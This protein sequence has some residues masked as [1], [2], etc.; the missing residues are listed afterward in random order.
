MDVVGEE[1]RAHTV[2]GYFMC[3]DDPVRVVE[4]VDKVVLGKRWALIRDPLY[5]P[6]FRP[7]ELLCQHGKHYIVFNR[8]AKRVRW[9]ILLEKIPHRETDPS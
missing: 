1:A 7:I 4:R 6:G 8:D 3:T 9:M 2:R 5:M